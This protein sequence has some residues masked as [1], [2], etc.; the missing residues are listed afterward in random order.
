MAQSVSVLSLPSE[1]PTLKV[2]GQVYVGRR[3][4]FF[5]ALRLHRR[6]A[7]YRKT[8]K[9]HAEVLAIVRELCAAM[10]IPAEPVLRLP[11]Y[12]ALTALES[13]VAISMSRAAPRHHPR[14]D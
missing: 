10:N 3:M 12:T 7:V 2:D 13:L 14:K 9:N 5:A 6:F 1:P 11:L 8:R 4:S